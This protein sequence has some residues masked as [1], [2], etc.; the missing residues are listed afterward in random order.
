LLI[1][2]GGLGAVIAAL[3]SGG[4]L[5]GAL[6][7]NSSRTRARAATMT[8]PRY[9]TARRLG[10][11]AGTVA[12]GPGTVVR[13]SELFGDRVFANARDGFALANENFVEYPARTVDGGL[14]WRID[15]PQL[16]IP[17]AHGA[18][19]VRY[20][21]LSGPRTFFAYGSSAVDVT[22]N[23]GRTWSEAFLGELV[24]AVVPGS[25]NDLIAYVQQSLSNGHVNPAV[26][27]QYVSLDG[28]RHWRFSRALA[29][30]Y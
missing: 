29:G 18:D 19:A 25:R 14:V 21:G 16:H 24:M 2:R 12:I 3:A 11:V 28:G 27:W 5:L 22:M 13:P 7:T 1:R 17:G 15:G 10:P 9:I 23:S 8:A 20:V 26:T 6:A 30:G 4:V